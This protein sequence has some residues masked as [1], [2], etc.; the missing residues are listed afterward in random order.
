MSLPDRSESDDARAE[1]IV[2]VT[3]GSSGIGE[4][5]VEAFCREGDSVVSLSRRPYR[6]PI[7]EV[8]S[9]ACNVNDPVSV[10]TAVALVASRYGRVDVLV[11]CAGVTRLAPVLDLSVEEWD[12]VIAT[13]LRGPFL[14]SQA[15]GRLM[16]AQGAGRIVN[17]ASLAGTVVLPE[18]SAYSASKFGLLG[19]TKSMALEWGPHGVTVNSVSPTGV[20]T[21]MGRAAWSGSRGEAIVSKIPTGRFAESSEVA[22]SV[23]FLASSDAGMINGADLLID[24]GYS[25]A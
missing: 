16:V 17:V 11:N 8:H 18:H 10:V 9:V 13:N 2:V 7:K 22:A 21:P 5:I 12:L 19:L 25:I 24:G 15:V 1:R 3:G 6:G 20:M 4:E 23:V 14:V